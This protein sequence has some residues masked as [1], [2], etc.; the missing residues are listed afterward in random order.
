MSAVQ[1]EKFKSL[2][3]KLSGEIEAIRIVADRNFLPTIDAS[4][5]FKQANGG[6]ND[7]G[8]TIGISE[9]FDSPRIVP[10]VHLNIC[11]RGKFGPGLENEPVDSVLF[12]ISN[13]LA[14]RTF[15]LDLSAHLSAMASH[16]YLSD[17][18]C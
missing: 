3:E 1:T 9:N 14:L 5:C 4:L 17:T 11:W 2:S 15:L 16:E 10:Q 18:N 12:A 6:F 7:L 13:R 8:I